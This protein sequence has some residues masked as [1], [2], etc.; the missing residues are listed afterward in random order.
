MKNKYYNKIELKLDSSSTKAIAKMIDKKRSIAQINSKANIVAGNN[1]TTK[2]HGTISP[3]CSSPGMLESVVNK[4]RINVPALI[5]SSSM[6]SVLKNGQN[7]NVGTKSS[8]TLVSSPISYKFFYDF[9]TYQPKEE[10]SQLIRQSQL[11]R[12]NYLKLSNQNVFANSKG[13]SNISQKNSIDNPKINHNIETSKPLIE[14]SKVT[15]N[16]V[17]NKRLFDKTYAGSSTEK[18]NSSRK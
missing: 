18:K 12:Y 1:Y 13:Q 15:Y 3:S 2:Q 8:Q 4:K 5:K 16:P 17:I 11:S 10:N 6:S 7:T 9:C 14:E